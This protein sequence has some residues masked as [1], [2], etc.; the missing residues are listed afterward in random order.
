LTSAIVAALLPGNY[1][2][3]VRGKDNATGVALV[4]VYTLQ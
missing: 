3:V 4:E 1:T 2:G